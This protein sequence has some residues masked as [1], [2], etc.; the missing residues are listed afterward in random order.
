MSFHRAVQAPPKNKALYEKIEL[1][2][3][4][5]RAFTAWANFHL[6]KRGKSIDSYTPLQ[7]T[8]ARSLCCIVF[9]CAT[10][11]PIANSPCVSLTDLRD[12]SRLLL[13]TEIISGK[14]LM[15]TNPI[16]FRGKL[17]AVNA[18]LSWQQSNGAPPLTDFYAEGPS[19]SCTHC[20]MKFLSACSSLPVDILDGNTEAIAAVLWPLVYW[21][22]L[23]PFSPVSEADARVQMLVWVK[24]PHPLVRIDNFS[25][26]CCLASRRTHTQSQLQSHM[27]TY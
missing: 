9:L 2:K 20:R 10:L 8:F 22:F 1:E 23:T 14:S 5:A 11:A 21:S 24:N 16:S 27:H 18:V 7:L 12:A 25:Q 26:R 6:S 13:L 3:M 19:L 4:Q 17:E 15:R